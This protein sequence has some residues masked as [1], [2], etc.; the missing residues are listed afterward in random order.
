MS[1]VPLQP[2]GSDQEHIIEAPPPSFHSHSTRS[3]GT[4]EI[5]L[6]LPTFS[7]LGRSTHVQTFD[8]AH[9]SCLDRRG[10][11]TSTTERPTSRLT[12][13]T[14]GFSDVAHDS[15]PN[16][17]FS[18]IPVRPPLRP[19]PSYSSDAPFSYYSSASLDLENKSMAVAAA[20]EAN[21]VHRIRQSGLSSYA[22]L[23]TLFALNFFCG[24]DT[25]AFAL[26]LPV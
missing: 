25:S 21:T 10:C 19:T 26:I 8:V 17:N 12:G 1:I 14:Q 9:E 7:E 5:F 16:T 11:C 23:A 2:S 13:S 4:E 15:H 3:E 24:V 20:E 18:V 22:C 6:Q